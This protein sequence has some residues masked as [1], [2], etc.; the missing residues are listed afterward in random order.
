MGGGRTRFARI[1]LG[2]GGGSGTGIGAGSQIGVVIV[3]VATSVVRTVVVA[4][5]R[6]RRRPPTFSAALSGIFVFFSHLKEMGSGPSYR[7]AG[8][9]P[10][11]PDAMSML[12]GK[13]AATGE[14]SDFGGGPDE[15]ETPELTAAR[16]AHEE[17]LGLLGSPDRIRERIVLLSGGVGH[18][19]V[20][21]VSMDAT[22][23]R[24]FAQKRKRSKHKSSVFLE[25]S[26]IRWVPRHKVGS[27]QLRPRV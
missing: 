10:M 2:G 6:Q 23:P 26:E 14:W 19:Y 12:L 13:E 17:S 25:K 9:I 4:I 11:T 8:V 22:L 18:H 27:L 3:A 24:R 1:G 15:N 5:L 16:E 7:Y 21:E 20:M